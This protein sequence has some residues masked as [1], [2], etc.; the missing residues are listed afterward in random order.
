MKLTKQ[1]LKEIIKEELNEVTPD[2]VRADIGRPAGEPRPDEA[3]L[4]YQELR[5]MLEKIA[6]L[7]GR[8]EN[9][10]REDGNFVAVN[11][12]VSRAHGALFEL[13]G[14]LEKAMIRRAQ[15]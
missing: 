12:Y 6:E 11:T 15:R 4:V 2:E 10:S 1:K 3:S 9:I 7:G 5:G 8:V 14:K 13:Y